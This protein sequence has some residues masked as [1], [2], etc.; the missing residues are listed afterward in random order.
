MMRPLPCS[1]RS[2]GDRVGSR[3]ERRLEAAVRRQ[4][5]LE[6]PRLGERRLRDDVGAVDV[7]GEVF[8]DV[9]V[10][11][12]LADDRCGD[13]RRVA[14]ADRAATAPAPWVVSP[15]SSREDRAS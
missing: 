14:A 12:L 3:R 13:D 10:P 1:L 8:A 2:I 6:L 7:P 4:P 15:Y 11:A 9:P 5:D